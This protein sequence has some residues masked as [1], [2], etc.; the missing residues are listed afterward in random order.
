MS[1]VSLSKIKGKEMATAKHKD[2]TV[3]LNEYIKKIE[4]NIKL[5]KK[6]NV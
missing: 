2:L 3:K 1:L 6:Y 5:E 4:E